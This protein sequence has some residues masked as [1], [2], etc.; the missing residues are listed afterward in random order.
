M[1]LRRS[2]GWLLGCASEG[3]AAEWTVEVAGVMAVRWRFQLAFD[4][5]FPRA[6]AGMDWKK[7]IW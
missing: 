7:V 6:V 2:S 5:C 3:M 1:R 4:L